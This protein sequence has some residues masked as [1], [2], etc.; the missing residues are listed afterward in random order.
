MNWDSWPP[1]RAASTG[2]RSD[3]IPLAI[4]SGEVSRKPFQASSVWALAAASSVK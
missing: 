3:A 4:S 1:A 2:E